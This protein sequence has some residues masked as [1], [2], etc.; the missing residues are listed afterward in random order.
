MLA[1][2]ALAPWI[3]RP[4]VAHSSS[5]MRPLAA[6]LQAVS[7]NGILVFPDTSSLRADLVHAAATFNGA[8]DQRFRLIATELA[9]DVERY[10]VAASNLQSIV[11][12]DISAHEKCIA[13]ARWGRC[14]IVVAVNEQEQ[15]L[16]TKAG[17]PPE[18]VVLVEDFAG[19]PFDLRRS[20]WL[21]AQRLDTLAPSDS[22][23]LV[24]RMIGFAKKIVV[25]DKMIGVA[26]ARGESSVKRH[27]RGVSYLIDAWSDASPYALGDLEVEIVS[28]AGIAGAVEGFINPA[29]ARATIT[30]VIKQL[31]M[32]KNV[33]R[34]TITLKQD[35]N[36]K[37]F[38]DRLL[39]CGTRAWGVHHGYDDI[40]S[41]M[42]RSR[43][44]TKPLLRPTRIEP[45][46]DALATT[47]RDI[48]ALRDA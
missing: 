18:R 8:G 27:L 7:Q 2:I 16:C 24:G 17:A 29:A 47:F 5:I 38:N 39:V 28:V 31:G 26:T 6:V 4:A 40:G 32:I 21:T 48:V 11:E 42:G 12:S 23:E 14:D 25:A 1:S 46:S 34:L 13:S 22:L 3:L 20:E 30:N 15:Q 45:A 35:G 33:G 9:K 41:L 19:S 10:S 37:I 43:S 44:N 36:P